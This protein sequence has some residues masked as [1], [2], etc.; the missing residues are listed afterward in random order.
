MAP[1]LAAL[2]EFQSIVGY[3]LDVGVRL[4]AE[5][6]RAVAMPIVRRREQEA[7]AAEAA[8]MTAEAQRQS[9]TNAK[10][11]RAVAD[12]VFDKLWAE[13]DPDGHR[14]AW[15]RYLARKRQDPSY[16]LK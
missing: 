16:S 4:V 7:Q 1:G 5:K 9:E 2:G 14:D 13:V 6:A 12:P 15:K 11:A 10:L 8:R 3:D